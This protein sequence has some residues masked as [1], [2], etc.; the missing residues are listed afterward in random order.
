VDHTKYKPN[1]INSDFRKTILSS[2]FEKKNVG[3][4]IPLASSPRQR[5]LIENPWM[6][7]IVILLLF[8]Y[9]FL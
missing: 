1:S 3:K 5:G 8:E 6:V 2:V 7:K 9:H 4:Q